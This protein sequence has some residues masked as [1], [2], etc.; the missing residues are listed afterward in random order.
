MKN[1]IVLLVSLFLLVTLAVSLNAQT[2]P[3]G[4]ELLIALIAP[5]S[6]SS[7]AW[8]MPIMRG[9]EV[10]VED[11]NKAGGLK[12]GN[13]TYRLKLKGYDHKYD[14]NET[15][16]ATRKAVDD[17][18]VMI[19]GQGGGVMPAMQSISEAAG[20]INVFVGGGGCRIINP[21]TP[22]SFQNFPSMG[23]LAGRTTDEFIPFFKSKKVAI[24]QPDDDLGRE[25]GDYFKKYVAKA[26]PNVELVAEEYFPRGT[27]D[28]YPVLGRI[29]KRNADYIFSV[30]TAQGNLALVAKQSRELG[31]KG[32]I[33]GATDVTPTQMI[34]VG[35]AQNLDL[36]VARYHVKPPTTLFSELDK[37]HLAKYGE[38]ATSSFQEG[39]ESVRLWAKGV[40]K[41]GTL[42][43]KKVAEVMADSTYPDYAKGPAKWS[44]F[45]CG[46]KHSI[47]YS[48]EMA[49]FEGGK[50]YDWYDWK[51]MKKK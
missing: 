8:G 7:A 29:M 37:R 44:D 23:M 16:S 26:Y 2:V 15:V 28:F 47:D 13:R 49:I 33:I 30:N 21:Q 22:L 1:V 31:Y 41:A 32:P 17:G 38:E 27:T 3:K 6:G 39:Y 14:A 46:L 19:S 11:T 34:K 12:V 43:S 20:I 35:G 45:G 50:T 4:D 18:A 51:A 9:G 40:Q 42:D 24:L 48:M 10:F 5:L 25:T 36:V